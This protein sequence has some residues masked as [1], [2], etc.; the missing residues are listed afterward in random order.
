MDQVGRYLKQQQTKVRAT[1][2]GL[3]LDQ[4]WN[5]KIEEDHMGPILSFRPRRGAETAELL[6]PAF[7]NED[8]MFS[9]VLLADHSMPNYGRDDSKLGGKG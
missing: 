5:E 2:K 8:E 9:N 1:V 3:V 4:M 7:W 6:D